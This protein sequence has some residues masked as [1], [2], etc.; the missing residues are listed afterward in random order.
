MINEYL[1]K[2]DEEEEVKDREGGSEEGSMK[3]N[4]KCFFFYW[5]IVGVKV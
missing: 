2:R 5:V 1:L 4:V 3:G